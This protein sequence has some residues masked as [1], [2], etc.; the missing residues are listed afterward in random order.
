MHVHATVR[1]CSRHARYPYPMLQVERPR[2]LDGAPIAAQIKAEVSADAEQAR[3]AG[4]TPGLAVVL[5]GDDPASHIYVRT[6]VKTCGEVGIRSELHTPSSSVSTEDLLALVHELNARNDVDGILIQL[7]LPAQVDTGRLLEAVDPSKD[8]DGFHPINAGRLLTD[9]PAHLTLAPCTPAGIMQILKRSA[10]P[11]HGERVVV[12][13]KSNIVGK[14][15]AVMLMNAGAT[16]SVVHKGTRDAPSL[17]READILVVA[18]GSPGFVKPEMVKPG[19]VLIDVGVNRITGE[20]EFATLFPGEHPEHERRR[21]AFTRRGSVV[22]GDVDPRTY[23]LASAYTPV[24]GGVG[25]LT[26]AMLMANTIKAAR[27]RRA[28]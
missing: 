15:I 23:A 2:V 4:Y 24:P 20:A 7:P 22:I 11:V 13:G 6:K 18:I 21:E 27:M 26:P 9:A 3:N 8:V 19:V 1:R 17:T 14:P 25:A 12:M 5:V 10:I 16:V 28:L